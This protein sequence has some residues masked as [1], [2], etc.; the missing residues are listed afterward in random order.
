MKL[1]ND[2]NTPPMVAGRS[3]RWLRNKAARLL[4]RVAFANSQA[5]RYGAIKR[6]E[7]VM[8]QVKQV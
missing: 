2:G 4:E 3:Q 7:Y 5:S 6:L 8:K 1:F